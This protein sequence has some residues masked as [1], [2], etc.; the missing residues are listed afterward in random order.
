LQLGAFEVFETIGRGGMGS[1]WHGRH[2]TTGVPV[3]VKFLSPNDAWGE[4]ARRMFRTEVRAVASL[5]H[6]GIVLVLDHG[7]VGPDVSEA[8]GVAPGTPYLIMELCS[9]GTLSRHRGALAWPRIR[10]L[11]SVLLAALA[12]A[13]AR[14]VIHRDIKP[15]N[16]LVGTALDLRRGIKLSD[17]G[18]AQVRDRDAGPGSDVGPIRASYF[19]GSPPYAPPE[20]LLGREADMGPWSDLY[21]LG[22][23]A[24]SLMCGAPP[25]ADLEYRSIAAARVAG[26]MPDFEPLDPTPPAFV[27]WLMRLLATRPGDRFRCAADASWAL[28]KVAPRTDEERAVGFFSGDPLDG[29]PTATGLEEREPES[30]F[31]EAGTRGIARTRLGTVAITLGPDEFA[32]VEQEATGVPYPPPAR[33]PLPDDWRPARSDPPTARL[34]GAGLGLFAFRTPRLVGREDERDR[35]WGALQDVVRTSMAGCL[36]VRGPSGVGKT[37]LV[38]WM[39]ERADELGAATIVRARHHPPS[40]DGFGALVRSLLRVPT[41]ALDPRGYVR[42]ALA[43]VGVEARWLEAAAME[44]MEAGSSASDGGERRALESEGER[45]EAVAALLKAVASSRPLILALD[46]VQWGPESLALMLRLARGRSLDRSPILV[47]ATVRDDAL[48]PGS[49]EDGELR[50]IVDSAGC[51][52]TTLE[53]LSVDE[54]HSLVSG[55]LGLDDDLEAEVVERTGGNPLFAVQLL[56]DWVRRGALE[57]G[58]DGF[59]R[60]AGAGAAI[61][62]D[63]HQLWVGRFDGVLAGGPRSWRRVLDTAA[64]LG[65]DFDPD[66]WAEASAVAVEAKDGPLPPLVDARLMERSGSRVRFVHSMARESLERRAAEA[67]RWEDAHRACARALA[68]SEAVDAVERRGRHRLQ[69]GDPEGA[70]LDLRAAATHRIEGG[71][72]V[73]ADD[74]LVQLLEALGEALVPVLDPRRLA[75]RLDRARLA[76][77]SGRPLPD[78][79]LRLLLDDIRARGVPG[80]ES[81]TLSELGRRL[82]DEGRL[83]EARTTVRKALDIADEVEDAEAIAGASHTLGWI[84]LLENETRSAITLFTR[85]AEVHV[86]RGDPGGAS[87]AYQGLCD[88]CLRLRRFDDARRYGQL[89]LSEAEHRGDLQRIGDSYMHLARVEVTEAVDL[90]AA[91]EM[92]GRARAAQTQAGSRV[93]LASTLNLLGEVARKRGRFAV[94]EQNYRD[95]LDLHEVHIPSFTWLP[96]LNLAVLAMD[97]GRFADAR[98]PIEAARG[99]LA[100]TGRRALVEVADLMLL[101]ALLADEDYSAFDACLARVEAAAPHW[102]RLDKECLSALEWAA[103]MAKRAG[104]WDGVERLRAVAEQYR[105]RLSEGM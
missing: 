64:A 86:G 38:R 16:V 4:S 94:A 46:D 79:A 96:R 6:P 73:A 83:D 22:C 43:R 93:A 80:L 41:T 57:V 2:R 44:L 89:A 21:A 54:Q 3:A 75:A 45:R 37:R 72:M 104:H 34:V 71:E 90:K 81:R 67:G 35:V 49:V 60:V 91:E 70:A 40:G 78:G 87:V 23:L 68:P 48:V 18:L 56:G 39:T 31:T 10:P 30:A 24:W 14:G 17:F 42:R 5:A 84:R 58:S 105:A 103:P 85:A 82:R 26:R 51:S 9:G 53:P 101:P 12:H 63:I 28:E 61:P 102:R 7:E 59:H 66:E 65:M 50:A 74:L 98:A 29:W 20:Q 99:Q 69:G 11:L 52:E 97:A 47:L 77:R 76:R 25:H 13:H 55:L 62:D 95:A 36:V 8:A 1:V 27:A 32:E 19:A 15:A 33:A 92:L 88:A 100:E